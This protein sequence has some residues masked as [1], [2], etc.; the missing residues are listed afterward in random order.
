MLMGMMVVGS[1]AA[2]FPDVSAEDNTEAIAVL[3]AV[4]VMIGNENGEFE[5]EKN[6]TRNEMAVIMSKLML[7][8]YAADSYVGSHPFTDV[9]TWADKYV[10]ACYSAGII[11]GRSET[12]YDGNS[13]VT[14]V[15]AAAMMLRALGYEDLSKGAAQWDQPVAAKANE[16]NLFAGLGGAGNAAMNRNSVAKLSLNTLQATMVTTVRNG[17]DITLPDGTVIAGTRSYNLRTEKFG[18]VDAIDDEGVT[19]NGDHYGYLQLGEYLY[20]GDLEKAAG[21]PDS[22]GRPVDYKWVYDTEDVCD[23]LK[24]AKHTL[25]NNYTGK[26]LYNTLGKTVVDSFGS[27]TGK[28]GLNVYVDGAAL[29]ENGTYK[30]SDFKS[31]LDNKSTTKY[32]DT[33]ALAIGNGTRTEI[34]VSDEAVDV[35]IINTFG[36]EVDKVYTADDVK[37]DEKPYVLVGGLKFETTE[38]QEEDVVAYTKGKDGSKTVIASMEMATP[39]EGEV[40]KATA[41]KNFTVDGETYE[42]NRTLANGD[43]IGTDNVKHDVLVYVDANGYMIFKGDATASTD[44]AYVVSCGKG[45]VDRYDDSKF[46]FHAKLLFTDGTLK[47]VTLKDV[48]K[49]DGTAASDDDAKHAYA[50]KIVTYTEDDGDYKLTVPTGG[51]PTLSGAISSNA[52]LDIS[53]GVASMKLNNATNNASAN[54]ETVFLVCNDADDEDYDVYV[55]FKNV[56]DIDGVGSASKVAYA[57]KQGITKVV[58]VEGASVDVASDAD[59]IVIIGDKDSELVKEGSDEYYEFKAV[60]DGEETTVKVDKAAVDGGACAG[61][62]SDGGHE[63]A[64][65]IQKIKENS[66]GFITS[67][68]LY[69]AVGSDTT[70][71]RLNGT[72]KAS[73]DVVSFGYSGGSYTKSWSYADDAQVVYRDED[74]NLRTGGISLVRTDENDKAIVV[75]EKDKVIGV[76]VQ[77]VAAAEATSGYVSSEVAKNRPLIVDGSAAKLTTVDWTNT[78]KANTS[79]LNGKTL[80]VT[81]PGVERAVLKFEVTFTTETVTEGDDKK[82]QVYSETTISFKTALDTAVEKLQKQADAWADEMEAGEKN[83]TKITGISITGKSNQAITGNSATGDMQVFVHVDDINNAQRPE[84]PENTADVT[85]TLTEPTAGNGNSLTGGGADKDVTV[86]VVA[87]TKSVTITANK[88]EGQTINSNSTYTVEKDTNIIVVN[89]EEGVNEK[90]EMTFTL[91]VSEDKKNPIIYTVKVIVAKATE[92]GK[93]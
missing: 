50:N 83:Y 27:G 3:E 42:F 46:T 90:G 35:C 72:K 39:V 92:E 18:W 52:N 5:P 16:I 73:N 21:D 43:K 80:S 1:S 70:V 66:K 29:D 10:A 67:Y 68:T 87:G 23:V 41:G 64:F 30:L 8:T 61:L 93:A 6:V 53:Q 51:A 55:G 13:T 31:A 48:P 47:E 79:S 63:E 57:T 4:K 28:R 60:I 85:F 59:M 33:S 7:G 15:E 91:T 62:K 84:I 69:S 37:D 20:K 89:T 26:D 86:N 2:S 88:A 25:K 76:F 74:G 36:G 49:K 65:V 34:F 44:Y 19:N 54:S 45:E 40:T 71:E 81:V 78:T 12:T 56:P 22:Q 77:E 14:A 17:Q 38:F 24:D 82:V 75:L 58:Y 9:P 32:G 11:A